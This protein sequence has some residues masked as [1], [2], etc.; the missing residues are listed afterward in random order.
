VS[1]PSTI[2]T[3]PDPTPV[4]DTRTATRTISYDGSGSWDEI[5]STLGKTQSKVNMQLDRRGASSK[6]I[7]MLY[8]TS[9]KE[10]YY[11]T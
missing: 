11:E 10:T 1:C 7:D 6:E 3:C 8:I 5:G 9:Y 4:L 2:Q